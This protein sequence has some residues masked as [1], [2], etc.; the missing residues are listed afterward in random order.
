MSEGKVS[1]MFGAIL[2]YLKFNDLPGKLINIDTLDGAGNSTQAEILAGYL[3]NV[4]SIQAILTKEPTDGVYGRLIRQ[5]LRKELTLD[6]WALQ[7]LFGVDRGDHLGNQH[8]Q[9]SLADGVWAVTARFS[10]SS[11]AFGVSQ[12]IPDWQL[13]AVNINYLWPNLNIILLLPVGE[14]LERIDARKRRENDQRELFEE[15]ATLERTLAAY[16]DLSVRLPNVVFVDGTGN[17]P[18]VFERVKQKVHDFLLSDK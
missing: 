6:K 5:V 14:C 12:G 17:P 4:L 8:L 3:N 16:K 15:K 2:P 1:D 11:L 13:L 9:A 7:L 18:Q 10:L